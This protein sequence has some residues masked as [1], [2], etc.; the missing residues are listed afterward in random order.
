MQCGHLL[1]TT[2]HLAT[3]VS[4]HPKSF[5][6]SQTYHINQSCLL[7]TS[8]GVLLRKSILIH[9]TSC[10]VMLHSM[11]RSGV[12]AFNTFS[13]IGGFSTVPVAIILIVVR[14]VLWPLC[15]SNCSWYHSKGKWKAMGSKGRTDSVIRS[16]TQSSTLSSGEAPLFE[17]PASRTKPV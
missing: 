9:V 1:H 14:V 13:Q 12:K 3:Y 6:T 15:T 2:A 16:S 17:S 7:S 4:F 10:T 8:V 5:R 11:S